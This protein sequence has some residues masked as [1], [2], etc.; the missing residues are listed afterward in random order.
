MPMLNRE[1]RKW[2]STGPIKESDTT[3]VR[4]LGQL[5]DGR[6]FGVGEGCLIKDNY[7]LGT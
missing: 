2:Y 3:F 5:V 7:K 6:T 1:E 4:W